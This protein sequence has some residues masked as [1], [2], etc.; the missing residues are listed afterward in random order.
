MRRGL[1]SHEAH[2]LMEEIL[3]IREPGMRWKGFPA[4]GTEK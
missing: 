3:S 4:L 1:Y 2:I